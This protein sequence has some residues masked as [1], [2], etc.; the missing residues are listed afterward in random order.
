[1]E[2]NNIKANWRLVL[3]SVLA[4]LV[5]TTAGCVNN[6]TTNIT[7]GDS[8]SNSTSISTTQPSD[9]TETSQIITTQTSQTTPIPPVQPLQVDITFPN[10]APTL[11]QI[12]ELKFTI[13]SRFKTAVDVE[14]NNLNIEASDGFEFVNGS[15]A[16]QG[17][18]P[19]GSSIEAFKI[20]VKSNKTGNWTINISYSLITHGTDYGG[21]CHQQIYVEV[22]ETS[23]RWGKVP[24]WA[25]TPNE[26][27]SPTTIPPTIT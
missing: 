9:T 27:V 7:T 22:K 6:S 24:L 2:E 5:F 11:N 14:I 8:T 23:A 19:P 15:T 17:V 1:M 20:D 12:A 13:T 16:W 3:T 4:I 25:E 18:I 26:P 10:G 21:D